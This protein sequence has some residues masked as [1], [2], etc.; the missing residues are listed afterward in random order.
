MAVGG[1]IRCPV[2]TSAHVEPSEGVRMLRPR[3]LIHLSR[4]S[5]F[6]KHPDKRWRIFDSFSASDRF[7]GSQ[8]GK[9]SAA[10]K[11][12]VTSERR[13]GLL[14]LLFL[15]PSGTYL[16]RTHQRMSSGRGGGGGGVVKSSRGD[17]AEQTRLPPLSRRRRK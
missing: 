6:E 3:Q 13:L 10:H 9:R 14:L 2:I 7:T 8:R 1:Q 15:P 12:R 16:L 17:D 5:A 11:S 4:H